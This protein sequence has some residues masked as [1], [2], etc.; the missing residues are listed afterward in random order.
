MVNNLKSN[1]TSVN[2]SEEQALEELA[3]E[4]LEEMNEELKSKRSYYLMEDLINRSVRKKISCMEGNKLSITSC[5][6][7]NRG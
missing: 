3:K 1:D 2:H 5:K 7:K 6:L 4:Q